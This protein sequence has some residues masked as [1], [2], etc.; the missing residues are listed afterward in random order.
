MSSDTLHS[1]ITEAMTRYWGYGSFRPL[2]EPAMRCVM[3]DRNSLVVLPTGGGKSLCF[4]VPA[5]CRDGLAVVVSPLI[6]LMKDQVDA[7]NGC[8]V[9]AAYVNSTLSHSE[10]ADVASRVRAGE[11]RLLYMAPERLVVDRTI[12]F[13]RESNVN[14]FAIDE[15][16]CISEW[17]HDFRPEYRQLKVLKEAFPDVAVH[18]YTA[19]ATDRVRRDIGRNLGL[20]EM[21]TL[22]GSFDRPNLSYKVEMRNDVVQQVRQAIERHMDESGIVY[23]I[24]RKDVDHMA[25]MLTE[26]GF[27]ALPYHA[28]LSADERKRNQD[29]FITDKTDIIVATV[30]FGMGIDKPNVRFVLHAGMPKSLENYQQESGRAGRDGLEAECSLFYSGGDF[31]TWKRMLGD[32][33]GDAYSGAVASLSKMYDYC[34][35]VAC[36]HRALVQ[37]FDEEYPSPNCGACDVCLG[38]FEP[39][40]EPM[41]MGQKILSCVIRLSEQFGGEYTSLVLCGSKDKRILERGHDELKTWGLLQDEDRRDVRDWIE[42]LVGQHFLEKVGE[43]SQLK[44]TE[45]GWKILRG[46]TAPRLLKPK[47]PTKSKAAGKSKSKAAA[48]SWEG[49][50]EGLFDALRT[51]RTEIA[52]ER[53]VPPYIVFG[54]TTLR[55]LARRRPTSPEELLKARG[56]GEKKRDE[57]SESFLTA[58]VAYCEENSL[59]TDITPDDASAETPIVEQSSPVERTPSRSAFQAFPLFDE[60]KSVAE[61]AQAMDRAESTV[62]GYLSSYLTHNKITDA[63]RWVSPEVITRVEEVADELKTTS[64]REMFEALEEAVDY[65]SIRIV[66][67]C[68]RRREAGVED[69][70]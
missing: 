54:D 69:D 65:N 35:S 59:T 40:P 30:A 70:G 29:A 34:T 15:A 31:H 43:Y 38:D 22:V 3:E 10:R 67:S 32:L 37:Y 36:R 8:G 52:K 47:L 63:E 39:V 62:H 20:P 27:R 5:V 61:V 24:R 60:E 9:P 1:Q 25:T 58:I 42:Q 17:G 7:L 48:E 46:E 57:F 12:E 28:G 26:Y 64:L 49:V 2:Q 55:D 6:S 23:C 19:T 33:Q 51:L 50:D 21:E 68:R 56:I 13:L 41:I 18:A 45:T 11:L 66:L 16:H 44:V 4:Q 53:G 14:F